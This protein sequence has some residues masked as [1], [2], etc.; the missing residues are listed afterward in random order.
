MTIKMRRN[1]FGGNLV[2]GNLV[3]GNLVGRVGSV[4][5][6]RSDVA[7]VSL[8]VWTLFAA[9]A[10]AGPRDI[11]ERSGSAVVSVT[12]FVE[13]AFM[14]EVR[15]V[16]GRDLGILVTQDRIMMNGA[17]VGVS[18]TGSR[19]H[20][21]RVHFDAGAIIDAK[22]IGIDEFANIAILELASPA[23]EKIKP[24]SF[25][26]R[27]QPRVGDEVHVLGLLPA[28]LEPMVHVG[29]G[30]VIAAVQKPKPF[31]IT[32]LFLD[33]ALGGPVF[34]ASGKAIGV[35][36][37][38]GGAGPSFASGF[39]GAE[40][41]VY[42]MI[43]SSA[44]LNALIADPPRDG[45]SR[46]AWL[47]IT[48]QA[49]TA[50]M[51]QYWGL[52]ERSGIIVNSVVPMSPAARAGLQEGDLLLSMDGAP[53]PVNQEE[54]VPIFVDQVGASGAGTQIT[55][56]VVRDGKP[57]QVTVTLDAAPKS[58]A[59]A[60]TYRSPE[61]EMTV[62]ELV[63]SDYRAFDLD[64][65]F[66]GVLISKVDE[67]GWS[68]V[69]G[70]RPGDIIRRVGDKS[71][72]TPAAVEEVLSKAVSVQSKKLVFFVERFGRTQFITVQPNWGGQS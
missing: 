66:K 40:Q 42:A 63:F 9:S 6:L 48:L 22:M 14:R 1:L 45:E 47:G 11:Y 33:D 10:Q 3:G 59:D 5:R 67:G 31:L 46:R 52:Q 56:G 15:E 61:F 28:N 32:D 62:R 4:S 27:A 44:T 50:D 26:E 70:L 55:F 68:A 13:T 2:G 49:L 38:M 39:G 64:P 71:V 54:H 57:L 8:V 60:E 23:P 19:P 29:S 58:R 20:G 51:A 17:V 18:S 34:N 21:F 24:L 16:E 72:E 41:G 65:D 35:L 7:A 43:I 12:Y 36:A 53:V 30:R 69:G 25:E 37:E